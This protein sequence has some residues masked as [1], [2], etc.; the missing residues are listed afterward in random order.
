MAHSRL[1]IFINIRVYAR[2]YVLYIYCNTNRLW[3]ICLG[4]ML[5]RQYGC[6]TTRKSIVTVIYGHEWMGEQVSS[7]DCPDSQLFVSLSLLFLYF[8]C[9]YVR[10]MCVC[11]LRWE[12]T[13]RTYHYLGQLNLYLIYFPSLIW[14]MRSVRTW[15][16]VANDYHHRSHNRLC[17]SSWS[18]FN[19]FLL[20]VSLAYFSL[21]IFF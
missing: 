17:T 4:K 12:G 5:K 14:S 13:S 3:N 21:V 19:I 10:A 6:F 8:G 1:G 11:P 16:R 9:R 2:I 18:I 15:L 20:I 7:F